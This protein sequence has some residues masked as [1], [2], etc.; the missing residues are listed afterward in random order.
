[1]LSELSTYTLHAAGVYGF[2]SHI[3][4]PCPWAGTARQIEVSVLSQD[5]RHA[6][7]AQVT[8]VAGTEAAA[9]VGVGAEAWEAH[10]G[11]GWGP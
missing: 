1:M 10:W 11:E 8:F 6:V 9:E 5:Q 3:F 4:C 2:T 7:H